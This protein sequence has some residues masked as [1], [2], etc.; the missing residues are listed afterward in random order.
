MQTRLPLFEANVMAPI[1]KAIA[2]NESIEDIAGIITEVVMFACPV[3]GHITPDH[4]WSG[5]NVCL[6]EDCP[7]KGFDSWTEEDNDELVAYLND[8]IRGKVA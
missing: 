5:P 3:C 7:C 4:S 8:V 6:K 1:T 2:E